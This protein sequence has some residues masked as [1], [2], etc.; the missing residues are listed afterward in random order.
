VY[1]YIQLVGLVHGGLRYVIVTGYQ[2]VA[3][4]A[5][6]LHFSGPGKTYAVPLLRVRKILTG[7]Q[8]LL[9]LMPAAF[10]Q[11]VKVLL[12]EPVAGVKHLHALVLIRF[13]IIHHYI[14]NAAWVPA[15]AQ[16]LYQVLIRTLL[17]ELLTVHAHRAAALKWG[18][19]RQGATFH[20]CIF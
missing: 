16:G 11:L 20:V 4:K 14:I 7:W 18:T 12:H 3:P 1:K 9:Y 15:G 2:L 5:G 10:R 8:A 13:I 6:I 19:I 17:Y